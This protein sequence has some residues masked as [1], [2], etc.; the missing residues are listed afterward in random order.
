M[1]GGLGIWVDYG[2][3]QDGVAC[4]KGAVRVDV[5]FWAPRRMLR[6]DGGG[7]FGDAF[8]GMEGRGL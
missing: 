4:D 2:C 7:L 3:P 8:M 1:C 6:T 5:L